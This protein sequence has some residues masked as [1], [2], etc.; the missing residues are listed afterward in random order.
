MHLL[1]AWHSNVPSCWFQQVSQETEML[2]EMPPTCQVLVTASKQQIPACIEVSSTSYSF[3]ACNMVF[4]TVANNTPRQQHSSGLYG[5]QPHESS[6]QRIILPWQN[7]KMGCAAPRECSQQPA[8]DSLSDFKALRDAAM[9]SPCMRHLQP[10]DS[11]LFMHHTV[12]CAVWQMAQA[13]TFNC[14]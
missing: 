7:C 12:L 1:H 10:V 8:I 13:H 11:A 9:V 3:T 4:G 5:L 14:R 6:N 2:C